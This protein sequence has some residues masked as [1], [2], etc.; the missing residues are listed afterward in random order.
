MSYY[1][2]VNIWETM[3]GDKIKELR[4]KK[5]LLQ[6]QI[7]S[8]LNVDTA[9]IS[10]VENNDKQISRSHL[11][12]LADLLSIDEDELQILWLADKISEIL[13]EESLG[14]KALQEVSR[15]FK[16]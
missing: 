13:K 15:R 3:L 7:A 9:Y 8:S 4:E 6:R 12:E 10:K 2:Q 5:G 1:G 14:F 16:S 11:S